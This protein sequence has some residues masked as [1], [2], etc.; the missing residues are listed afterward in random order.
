MPIYPP[1][2]E[3]EYST[4]AHRPIRAASS[5]RLQSL[6]VSSHLFEN[7]EGLLTSRLISGLQVPSASSEQNSPL[8]FLT[9]TLLI[10]R[11]ANSTAR[12]L[13][14]SSV[15]NHLAKGRPLAQFIP[16]LHPKQTCIRRH[17]RYNPPFVKV[18]TPRPAV[19]GCHP[20]DQSRYVCLHSLHRI[21]FHFSLVSA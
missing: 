9:L 15:G 10:L 5:L 3:V 11:R 6:T 7:T 16:P 17:Y 13:D 21:I 1:V 4:L 19:P 14:V 12:R 18:G 8:R 2:E 20:V